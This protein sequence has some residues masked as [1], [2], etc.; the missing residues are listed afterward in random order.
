MGQVD[1]GRLMLTA[2]G[3]L[4]TD[5]DSLDLGVVVEMETVDVFLRFLQEIKST[6]PDNH[7]DTWGEGH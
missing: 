5:D 7:V 6:G 2:A 1:A 4:E 3:V